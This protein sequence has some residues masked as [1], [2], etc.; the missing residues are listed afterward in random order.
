[1]WH[2]ELVHHP[3]AGR[4]RGRLL[5]KA[6]ESVPWKGGEAKHLDIRKVVLVV[7]EELQLYLQKTCATCIL[8][9]NDDKDELFLW[10]LTRP[11]DSLLP[12]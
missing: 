7:E 8:I 11:H 1:M 5:E 6:G 9:S 12:H 2:N 3:A 4:S 10:I